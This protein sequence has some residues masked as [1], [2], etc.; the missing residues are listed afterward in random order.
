MGNRGYTPNIR[1]GETIVNHRQLVPFF[2]SWQIGSHHGGRLLSM[3]ANKADNAW[4]ITGAKQTSYCGRAMADFSTESE[5]KRKSAVLTK[6]GR[7]W[8][9]LTARERKSSF[10]D[11]S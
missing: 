5:E 4:P 10:I 11:V 8:I 2:F 3:V 1:L 9:E 7:R 6:G